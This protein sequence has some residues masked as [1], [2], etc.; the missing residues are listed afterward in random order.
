M[1]YEINIRALADARREADAAKQS[2]NALIEQVKQTPEYQRIS[3]SR[4]HYDGICETII[5]EI[6]TNALEIYTSE[7]NK[8]PHPA[9]QVKVFSV[10]KIQNDAAAREWCFSNFRPALKLDTKTFEKAAR[11]G[12]IPA[13]LAVVSD[14]ARVQIATDLSEYLE[15]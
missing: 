5:S 8:K 2:M 13:D 1:D 7:Q 15:G 14:D 4:E 3:A 10:V 6:Q 12:N 11:D 9:V